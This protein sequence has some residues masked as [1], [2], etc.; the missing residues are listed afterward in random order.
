MSKEKVFADGFKFKLPNENAPDW[1][2]GEMSVR[3]ESAIAWLKTY[4][5]KDGYVNLKIN[6]SGSSQKPYIQLDDF[7]PDSK[8]RKISAADEFERRQA[9]EVAEEEDVDELPF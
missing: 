4:V 7:V 1:V 6:I 2:V 9:V 8:K 3:V 5:K